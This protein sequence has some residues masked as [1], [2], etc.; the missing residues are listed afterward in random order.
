MKKNEIGVDEALFEIKQTRE[1][2]HGN[3][4]LMDADLFIPLFG[5]KI[6]QQY[7]IEPTD[8]NRK[9]LGGD[10]ERD[11][12]AIQPFCYNEKGEAVEQGGKL[13]YFDLL[14]KE[15]FITPK[16]E[17]PQ[18]KERHRYDCINKI[19]AR[20]GKPINLTEDGG[21]DHKDTL[22]FVVGEKEKDLPCNLRNKLQ[23]YAVGS[24]ISLQA[25]GENTFKKQVDAF[26]SSLRDDKN[27]LIKT[28]KLDFYYHGT[29]ANDV[30]ENYCVVKDG[31]FATV[32]D[33]VAD[34]ANLT[35][36]SDGKNYL[37]GKNLMFNNFSC[38]QS[39]VFQIRTINAK[40]KSLK[41]VLSSLAQGAKVKAI[42]TQHSH[43][44]TPH[45]TTTFTRMGLTKKVVHASND[46]SVFDATQPNPKWKQV[47]QYEKNN[48]IG[49]SF[50]GYGWDG[51]KMHYSDIKK[52]EPKVE[53]KKQ[54][55]KEVYE[56][57]GQSIKDDKP[58]L[59]KS[60]TNQKKNG[61]GFV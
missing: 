42:L 17:K 19:V 35:K 25:D 52:E 20:N 4:L 37:S 16:G 15:I 12:V 29:Q 14:P 24:C 13:T 53:E 38:F 61:N 10:F 43:K 39:D 11:I 36:K 54:N 51:K 50:A 23:K 33:K 56:K 32:I 48:F 28:V 21:K 2:E 59:D 26:T 1:R 31:R 47:S 44:N 22:W 45:N 60:N 41:K 30:N 58:E 7:R 6:L 8:E 34:V 27:N 55:T 57:I 9:L 46:Y 49:G 40:G 18:L 5:E 3:A